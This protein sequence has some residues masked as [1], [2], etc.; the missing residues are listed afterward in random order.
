MRGLSRHWWRI[1]LCW[2]VLSAPLAYLIYALVEP[3]YDAVSLLRAEPT[4]A[5]IY[6]QEVHGNPQMQEVKPYLQTQVSLIKS[7]AVLDAAL[8]NP[9]I[10][11]LPM[12]AQSKD[13]KAELKREMIV[14]IVGDNTYLIQVALGSRDP[15]EAAAIVN[16][17][18][19][20]YIEQHAAT[21]RPPTAP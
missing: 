9:A 8:A 17:V 10:S 21:S 14:A 18:V 7:T 20:A 2:L 11:N 16:A 5:P 1:T 12:V 3:T 4:Q 13:P 15:A 6:S 19:D